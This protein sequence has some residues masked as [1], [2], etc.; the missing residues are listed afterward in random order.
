MFK[1]GDQVVHYKEGVCVVADIGKLDMRCSDKNKQYYTLKPVYN[2][3]GTL[4]MPVDGKEEQLRKVI[5][6]QEAKELI[7]S[8]PLIK[9][10]VIGDEKKRENFYKEALFKNQ[11]QSWIALIKT[12]YGRKQE[13]VR[14]GK[15]VINIDD[16]YLGSAEKFLLGELS[17][18]LEMPRDEL[19][20]YIKKRMA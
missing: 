1:I 16:R 12:S 13:R 7:Q 14:A 3:G 10:L 19:K 15:K 2:E 8:M 6:P 5:S 18:A 4:Y 20:K 9:E 17:V 11:C